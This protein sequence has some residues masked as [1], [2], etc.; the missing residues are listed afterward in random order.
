MIILDIATASNTII[1]TLKEKSQ[2]ANSKYK[3]E[4][5]NFFTGETYLFSNLSTIQ[6]E[7]KDIL[8]LTFSNE[9]LGR[10]MSLGQYKY[11]FSEW[12]GSTSSS[13][14]SVVE[15]GMA[16]VINSS[17]VDNTVYIEPAE[18]DDDYITL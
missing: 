1:A 7:R 17:V 8:S 12:I 11:T 5:Y 2:F 9:F 4:L 15:V 3:L 13:T 18:T 10:T 6:D 14:Y 16:K